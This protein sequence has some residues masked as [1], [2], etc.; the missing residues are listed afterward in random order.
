LKIGLVC[1]DFETGDFTQYPWE[2][3]GNEPWQITYDYP[4]EGFYSIKSG[5]I[6]GNQSSVISL[7]YTVMTADSISFYRKVSSEQYDRLRFFIDD[8]LAGEWYGTTSGWK[9]ESFAVPAGNRNFK[10]VYIKNGS[11]SNGADCAW[12][13]YLVFP[14]SNA[15]THYAGEDELV[16]GHDDFQTSGTATAYSTVSWTTSGSGTFEDNTVLETN[17][18]PSSQDLDDGFVTLSLLVTGNNSNEYADDMVLSFEADPAQPDL[19]QGPDYVNAAMVLLS[20]YSVEEVEAAHSYLWSIDPA[21]AGIFTNNNAATSIVWDRDFAGEATITVTAVNSCGG[22]EVSEGLVVTVENDLVGQQE[23]ELDAWPL[24]IYPNPNDGSFTVR[25]NDSYS[26]EASL[27]VVNI[28]GQVV[29]STGNIPGS[30]K[31]LRID[32]DLVPG[33]YF[34]IISNELNTTSRKIIVK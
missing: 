22:G 27:R 14:P 20:D 7:D 32:F 31:Q 5:S 26:I 9:R 3:D 11:G 4:F 19:P 1:E 15:T 23:L 8:E 30:T 10:W 33:I 29:Y 6:S 13:D 18:T 28:A 21:E 12:L 24:S 17:Y 2:Q 25:L 16:C 34:V